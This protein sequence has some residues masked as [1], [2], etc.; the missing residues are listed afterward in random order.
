M[1]IRIEQFLE[2]A[3]ASPVLDVRTPAEFAIGHIPGATNFPLFQD[4]ERKI[5]GTIYKNHGHIKAVLAGLNFVKDRMTIMINEAMN[6][7]HNEA[8]L[9][10]CWRGGMRS[11]S[12]AWLLNSA[13]IPTHTLSGG[14]KSFRNYALAFFEQKLNL[15][16]ISGPTGAGKTEILQKL[17]DKGEQVIDLE[18]L[19]EHKGSVF[20]G[21]GKEQ[22]PSSEHFQNLLFQEAKYFD[23]AKRVWIEDESLLIGRVSVP[24]GLWKQMVRA[25]RVRILINKNTRIQRLVNDYGS[26]DMSK[27]ADGI[28]RL[29]KRLGNKSMNDALHALKNGNLDE[30]ADILL[31]YY[32]KAYLNS[33]EKKKDTEWIRIESDDFSINSIAE[34]LITKAYPQ[35]SEANYD[36]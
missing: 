26:Q 30:T 32:D 34:Q 28:T 6:Y 1:K 8:I 18:K 4:E 20:G 33:F 24:E 3:S 21:I 13:R 19:A 31:T 9:L 7:S 25:P 35:T 36:R 11:E 14:Y 15:A 29:E 5:I 22:Q 27:L 12:V 2:M 17:K 16:V 10:H 23:L